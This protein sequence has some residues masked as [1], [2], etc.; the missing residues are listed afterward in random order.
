MGRVAGSRVRLRSSN[1]K[2][3]GVVLGSSS[4]SPRAHTDDEAKHSGGQA[5]LNVLRCLGGPPAALPGAAGTST[6]TLR[7]GR[8]ERHAAC[9]CACSAAPGPGRPSRASKWC[10][11][12]ALRASTWTCTRRRRWCW[13]APAPA[14]HCAFSATETW[15]GCGRGRMAPALALPPLMQPLVRTPLLLC[16]LFCAQC[17][18]LCV[19]PGGAAPL[20]HAGPRRAEV[21]AALAGADVFFASL[22]FD[23]D[24]AS[25]HVCTA[26]TAPALRA[27][28][29]RRHQLPPHGPRLGDSSSVL[30]LSRA[31]EERPGRFA[32]V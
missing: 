21:E 16:R 6:H 30:L 11:S 3:G 22:L 28:W 15:V 13:R 9:L 18:G 31:Q 23:F 24:Q 12:P 29:A 10:S 14:S 25:R 27:G 2:G 5:A 8:H 26:H 17:S 20:P 19:H 32:R 1:C 7:T 4:C